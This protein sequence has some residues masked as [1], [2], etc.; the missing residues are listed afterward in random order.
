MRTILSPVPIT[1]IWD[2]KP[3]K[4]GKAQVTLEVTSYIQTGK[5]KETVPIRVLQDTWLVE[6]HR[7]EWAGYQVEQLD[8]IQKFLAGISAAAVIV[9]AWF[10]IKGLKKDKPDFET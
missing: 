3:L 8:P 1:W 5:D 4:P 2:V 7:I 9:L 10:G 6:A